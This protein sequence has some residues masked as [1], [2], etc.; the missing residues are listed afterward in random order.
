[1]TATAI[2]T[3]NDTVHPD[4]K[5]AATLAAAL[6]WLKEYH[7]KTIVVKYGGNAMTNDA[8]KAAFAEDIAF[9]R[10][11]GFK[12]VVVHGGGPQINRMLDKLGIESEFRG[13]LRVTTPE[14]MDVVRMVLVGQV[15]RELVGLINSHGPLAVGLSGE[16]AGLFT[17]RATT[18][19]VD[20][21]EVD[22]G[23]V[24]EVAHVSPEAVLDLVQAGR[25]PVISSVAPDADG[26]VHN[27]N[28]DTAAAALAVALGA[29]KLLVLTDVEGLFRDYGNSDDVI[30]EIAPEALAEM[31][32][33]LDAG[34]VP[35]MRACYE[36]VTGGVHRATVVDGREPHAVLLEIFTD[37]G[38]GTQVLPGVAT[39]IRN[40]Y[41]S[42]GE[43]K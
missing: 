39:K 3:E 8:L 17:A 11:A 26:Q 43:S 7:G 36:A 15:Q 18:A 4:P 35:K 29:E 12:P 42:E 40:S 33:T 1:M 27:V 32:P 5:K 28:A 37:E 20:G 19:V 22:L 13:G 34:M 24:G 2:Q 41:A 16:D 23:L 10:F 30:Q 31:L 14:A 9:L 25:I 21:E 6:P 38:V